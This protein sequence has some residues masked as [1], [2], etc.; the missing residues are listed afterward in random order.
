MKTLGILL[1]S[2]ALAFMAMSFSNNV[3]SKSN[4]NNKVIEESF[5]VGAGGTLTIETDSGSIQV[6]SH[7]SDTVDVRVE[8]KGKSREN[9]TISFDQD[10]DDVRINGDRK[11]T[12]GFSWGSSS[13]KFIVKVPSRYNV[14]LDTSGGSIAIAALIG[15]V[16][17]YTSGG[18]IKLGKIVG[19]VNVKTSG[20][21]IKVDDVAGAVN[22]K[23]SGGSIRV[24]MSRQPEHDSKLSTSGGSVTAYL[25]PG[26]AVDLSASTSGGSV[27]SDFSVNGS[28]RKTSIEGEINGGGPKLVLRTSGGSVRVEKL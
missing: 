2:T 21:S 24:S 26:I 27:S 12:L 10:G 17:A 18:S 9:M 25:K 3:F 6:V 1:A 15:E 14:D 19:D 8:R 7:N 11:N 28:V 23:T 20:G 22:A 16:E 4:N 13:V 5:R